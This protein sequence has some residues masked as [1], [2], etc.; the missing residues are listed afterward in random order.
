MEG[1][2]ARFFLLPAVIAAVIPV[3]KV[4]LIQFIQFLPQVVVELFQAEILPFLQVM[5]DSFFKDTNGVF[6]GAFEFRFPDFGRENYSAIVFRPLCVIFIEFRLNPIFIG[7]YSL[8]AVIAYY[9]SRNTAEITKRMIIYFNPLRF[10]CRQHPLCV[11]VLRIGKN[12]YKNNDGTD[13]ASQA[14]DQ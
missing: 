5:E 9:N 4:L 10:F 8:F 11:Y 7:C 12:C 6:Y 13:L 2:E 14:I 3:F 1:A